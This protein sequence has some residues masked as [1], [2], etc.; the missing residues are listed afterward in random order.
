MGRSDVNSRFHV[1]R[2]DVNSR[3]HVGRSDVNSRFHVGG[4]DVKCSVVYQIW[5]Q[6]YLNLK[7][8]KCFFIVFCNCICMK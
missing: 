6:I 5:G 7:V 2:S 3:F 1:G 8:F 4:S